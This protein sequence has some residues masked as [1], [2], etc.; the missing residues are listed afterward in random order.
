LLSAENEETLS[1]TE[2]LQFI[3]N[4]PQKTGHGE[5]VLAP[6][7]AIRE[8]YEQFQNRHTQLKA[9]YAELS[10]ASGD[11]FLG[12]DRSEVE[13]LAHYRAAKFFMP[14]VS[15]ILDIGGQDIKCL[16]IKDGQLDKIILNEACSSGCGSFVE[17]FAQSLGY[18][19]ANFAKEGLFAE[20]PIDLGT[21][22][23][24]FMNSKV[25]QAQKENA[26][27]AD[28]SAG[29]SYSVAKNALY[30]VLKISDASELG[31]KV[32][33]QG[34][35]FNNPAVLR[36]FEH[37]LQREVYRTNISGIMGAFGA[38]LIAKD[39]AYCVHNSALLLGK[40][41][42]NF[43]VTTTQTRCHRCSNKCPLSVHKFGTTDIE[44][45]DIR[46]TAN[47]VKPKTFISGNRCDRGLG[48]E[49]ITRQIN[50]FREQYERIFAYYEPLNTP[51]APFGDIGLPKVLNMFE[52]FPFWVTLFQESG[53]RVVLS[54]PLSKQYYDKGL[55]GITSQTLCYPAKMVHG[56]ILNLI[57]K[58]IKRIFYPALPVEH[59]EFKESQ[60]SYNC[61]VVG[62]YPEVIRL[63][64][65][66]IKE[67]NIDFI[68]P[69]LPGDD[70]VKLAK[71]LYVDL[72][73]YGVNYHKLMQAA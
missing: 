30:K 39:K 42:E 22:C 26:T 45:M 58:G 21:R 16:S 72:K 33:V 61:P 36:A 10:Q 60:Y 14:D 48:K 12:I 34:G 32:I 3:D 24:V 8:E 69:F 13:T 51:C 43:A 28:I 57:D 31:T 71:L 23:T 9:E 68:Q 35:T 56:H 55:S 1:A 59:R 6:L 29:I 37:L 41:L 17:T 53:F 7:F 73:K 38:A 70:A 4:A 62:S 54:D 40:G 63:N 19:V 2:I 11:I 46:N 20:R 65:D 47:E 44:T 18:T 25:K 50:L 66:E 52:N 5:S 64:V 67:R 15:F 27:I 49:A